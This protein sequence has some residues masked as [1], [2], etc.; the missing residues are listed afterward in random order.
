MK[1]IKVFLVFIAVMMAIS[2]SYAQRKNGEVIIVGE[3][4]NVMWKG[5]VAWINIP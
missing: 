3:M 5:A 1:L 4:K 2:T